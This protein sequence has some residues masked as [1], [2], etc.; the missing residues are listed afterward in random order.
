MP[1][2]KHDIIAM[3]GE[4]SVPVPRV[5][6]AWRDTAALHRWCFPGDSS[7]ISRMDENDFN[8]GG[9]K[10]SSFGLR[11]EALYSEETRY[12]EIHPNELIVM[13]QTVSVSG[14]RVSASLICVEIEPIDGGTSMLLTDQIAL[15]D[16]TDSPERRRSGWH[17]MLDKLQREVLQP[18]F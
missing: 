9:R 16:S 14:K 6:A 11:G 10:R 7:W 8:V 5:F 4:F 1:V 3:A 15:F 12:L 2:I 18:T 13:A 17:E